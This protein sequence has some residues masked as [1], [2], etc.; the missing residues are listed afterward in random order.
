MAGLSLNSKHPF[1][2]LFVKENLGERKGRYIL[3]FCVASSF[4]MFESCVYVQILFIF[5]QGMHD[6]HFGGGHHLVFRLS[7]RNAKN[8]AVMSFRVLTFNVNGMQN[9][10]CNLTNINFTMCQSQLNHNLATKLIMTTPY[11]TN[12]SV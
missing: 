8:S 12:T 6:Y 7:Y 1:D 9:M 10:Y 4:A 3:L 11:N 5:R 2:S